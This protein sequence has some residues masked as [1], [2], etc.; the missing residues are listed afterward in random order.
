MRELADTR[1]FV[2]VKSGKADVGHS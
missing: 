1:H 2:Q